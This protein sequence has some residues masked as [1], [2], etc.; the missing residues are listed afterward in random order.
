MCTLPSGQRSTSRRALLSTLIHVP[1]LFVLQ[2]AARGE[3]GKS[4]G[5]D[6]LE[7]EPFDGLTTRRFVDTGRPQPDR[8]PPT[9]SKE[10]EVFKIGGD[11][12][13]QDTEVGKDVVVEDG[14]LVKAR[15]VVILAD[16][17]TVDDTQL[18]VPALFRPGAH[19]VVP[20]VEDAVLGMRRGGKRRVSMSAERL[21]A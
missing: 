3:S 4:K 11:I 14:S 16:G 7:P 12:Q 5:V 21:L 6:K 15:W 1:V 20:G 17:T 9:F 18:A 19:Q 13:A 8:T 2:Q 10:K